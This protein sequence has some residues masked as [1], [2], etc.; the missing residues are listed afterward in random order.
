MTFLVFFSFLYQGRGAVIEFV[1]DEGI[2][3]Q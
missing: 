1:L 3:S 2:H